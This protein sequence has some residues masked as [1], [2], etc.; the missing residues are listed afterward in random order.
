MSTGA[1][2]SASGGGSISYQWSIA[3][4]SNIA[5]PTLSGAN[6]ATCSVQGTITLN[7]PGTVDLICVI[8]NGGASITVS[9]RLNYN[10]F[11]TL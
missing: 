7:T 11:N 8:S 1:T 6:S 2:A 9:A 5:G 4:S 3:G 10:Y